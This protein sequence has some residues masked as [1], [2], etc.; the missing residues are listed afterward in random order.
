[1]S[2]R[3]VNVVVTGPE[4]SGPVSR[5]GYHRCSSSTVVLGEHE[6]RGSQMDSAAWKVP[7]DQTGRVPGAESGAGRLTKAPPCVRTR[8]RSPPGVAVYLAAESSRIAITIWF[9]ISA[10]TPSLRSRP[11]SRHAP[12]HQDSSTICRPANGTTHL[13]DFFRQVFPRPAERVGKHR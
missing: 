1:M 5:D 10:P 13:R 6:G 8:K 4:D 3:G 7:V 2:C 9:F 11:A 12:L